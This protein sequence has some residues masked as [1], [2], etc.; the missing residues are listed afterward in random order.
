[1]K[2]NADLHI[3]SMYSKAVSR[4][5][6][7]QQIAREASRKGINIVGTGDCLFPKWFDEIKKYP[8]NEGV[9]RVGQTYFVLNVEVEDSQRVHHLILVPEISK[10]EELREALGSKSNTV[11]TDGRPKL[12]MSGSE[13]ADVAIE[14]DC[15]L[16]PSHSFTPWTGI[17][18]HY[19]SLDECYQE[20]VNDIK[21]IE[22]G[23]SADTDY[24]D[25]IAELSNKTFLS[26]SDAHSPSSNKLAREFNQIEIGD[27]SFQEI[28]MAICR[29][30]G[31]RIT[32]NVGFHPEEGKYNRTACSRC[33]KQ[34]TP[35]QMNEF[36]G[37]CPLC[38]G[39]IKLGVRDRV[40]RLADY[41]M[42]VHPDHRPP[43]LH[44]IPLAEIISIALGVKSPYASSVQKSWSELVQGRTE[45]EILLK[46][47]LSKLDAEP[48]VLEAIEAFRLGRI[49]VIPGGGG[50][51]G[52]ISIPSFPSEK[53]LI[54][55]QQKS[56]ID[57]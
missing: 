18:A 34:Y 41:P 49:V 14:A 44:L 30:G 4:D 5:M 36:L 33:Y 25:R 53:P 1:M 8:N 31:R 24:A 22:L 16:G 7:L 6:N 45:I 43:Y 51:Y 15:L 38:N 2:V 57:F 55:Q 3:H 40:D 11:N 12:I 17:Y 28:K 42:P 13:I 52:E 39:L 10:V 35:N 54:K 47:D 32:L 23:L 19:D 20:K 9:F 46:T 29:N 27:I 48:K 50:K 26:N 56:L 21:F 37:R